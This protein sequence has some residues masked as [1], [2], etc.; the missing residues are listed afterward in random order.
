MS[1]RRQEKDIEFRGR[2]KT[3]VYNANKLLSIDP[4]LKGLERVQPAANLFL[5]LGIKNLA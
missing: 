1:G 2:A 5:Y 3:V 4:T